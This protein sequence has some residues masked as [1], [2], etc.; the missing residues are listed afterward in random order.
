MVQFQC[1]GI[2]LEDEPETPMGQA[3]EIL[4]RWYETGCIGLSPS[5]LDSVS[6]EPHLSAA[7]FTDVYN[8]LQLFTHD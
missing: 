7:Y 1:K 5:T 6:L 4:H 3:L 8:C 2:C